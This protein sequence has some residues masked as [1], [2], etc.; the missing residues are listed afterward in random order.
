MPC[1]REVLNV[2]VAHLH[3]VVRDLK[4]FRA[5]AYSEVNAHS[6]AG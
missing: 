3:S 6:A 5:V 1:A 4:M 2:N